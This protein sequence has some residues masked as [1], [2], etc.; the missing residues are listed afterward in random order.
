MGRVHFWDFAVEKICYRLYRWMH[1]NLTAPP[2]P[3]PQKILLEGANCRVPYSPQK[4]YTEKDIGSRLLRVTLNR[5]KNNNKDET[6]YTEGSDSE[7]PEK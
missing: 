1:L 2:P 7:K 6:K 4:K 5:R 3:P